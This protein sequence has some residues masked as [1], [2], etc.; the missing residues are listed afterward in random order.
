MS[1]K[2]VD[3]GGLRLRVREPDAARP[4]V[5][6]QAVADLQ[7][8]G[9][10]ERVE[11]YLRRLTLPETLRVEQEELRQTRVGLGAG[12]FFACLFSGIIVVGRRL[13]PDS[14]WIMAAVGLFY[15]GFLVLQR[16]SWP[17]RKIYEDLLREIKER[18]NLIQEPR[19]WLENPRRREEFVS[20][21]LTLV[22]LRR[23]RTEPDISPGTYRRLCCLGIATALDLRQR[24]RDWD[25]HSGIPPEERAVIRDWCRE[26]EELAIHAYDSLLARSE[27][28]LRAEIGA[29]EAQRKAF[30]SRSFRA[31]V[32]RLLSFK[33]VRVAE[34][35]PARRVGP[36]ERYLQRL[37]LPETRRAERRHLRGIRILALVPVAAVAGG[38]ALFAPP[39]QQIGW[40]LLGAVGLYFYLSSLVQSAY[41]ADLEREPGKAH[42]SWPIK[43]VLDE[44]IGAIRETEEK[45]ARYDHIR[46]GMPP[47]PGSLAGFVTEE[48]RKTP[49]DLKTTLARTGINLPTLRAL[50][51]AGIHTAAD[52]Q[53]RIGLPGVPP[54]RWSALR[55][56]R[57][58]LAD[59]AAQRYRE[60]V[61]R[62]GQVQAELDGME[63]EVRELQRAR[64]A[65]KRERNAFP[66]LS[67]RVYLR[68]LL[69]FKDAP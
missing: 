16:P 5:T 2:N 13:G 38:V 49:L 50:R 56:W 52:L 46:A 14:D 20:W 15:T 44:L 47:D 31:Y 7:S 4:S 43:R 8:A 53:D 12:L 69:G 67:F 21:R 25:S 37:T 24:S 55:D 60:I 42:A 18:E 58:D 9:S 54:D 62:R 1:E 26:R 64:T 17:R 61:E 32:G 3:I 29:L 41:G 27:P 66:D 30:P 28:Q 40:G 11:D 51:R 6:R 45:I 33:R 10:V 63:P 65:L 23:I 36:F 39:E 19:G 35:W 22:P 68:R 57:D 48:L 59:Q 34:E